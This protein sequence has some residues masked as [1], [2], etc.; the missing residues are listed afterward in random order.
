VIIEVMPNFEDSTTEFCIHK[1]RF[2]IAQGTK[3]VCPFDKGRFLKQ[4][5]ER[6]ITERKLDKLQKEDIKVEKKDD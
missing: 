6:E 2:G 1:D 4:I 3:F 5:S